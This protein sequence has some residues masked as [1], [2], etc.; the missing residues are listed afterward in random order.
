MGAQGVQKRRFPA[1]AEPMQR[2]ESSLKSQTRCIRCMPDGAGYVLTS[3]EGRVAVEY[4][5]EQSEVRNAPR[6]VTQRKRV[7]E[8]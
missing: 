5:A 7:G 1:R 8:R 6:P 2:R 3:V 4:F